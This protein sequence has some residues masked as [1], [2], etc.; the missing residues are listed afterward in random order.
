MV[1]TNK[2]IIESKENEQEDDWRSCFVFHSLQGT[3]VK[4][5]KITCN[6][7]TAKEKHQYN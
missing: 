7:M 5:C 4:F 1:V 6:E 3:N 2:A